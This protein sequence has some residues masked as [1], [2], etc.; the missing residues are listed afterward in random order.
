MR[1]LQFYSRTDGK[2]ED[3][4]SLLFDDDRV[5]GA[6]PRGLPHFLLELRRYGVQEH[7]RSF[8]PLLKAED[9][10]AG[11]DTLPHGP[12]LQLIDF[13][14]HAS[15]PF[16]LARFP[17]PLHLTT[18][19]GAPCNSIRILRGSMTYYL[20]LA[21]EAAMNSGRSLGCRLET[22]FLSSTTFSS[23]LC[24]LSSVADH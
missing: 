5:L 11:F 10:R 17:P 6:A 2:S 18:I 23:A 19:H 8:A 22:R 7:R 9:I 3:S 21:R 14:S 13:G 16:S 1:C 20:S 24:R 15:P 12:A 4:P